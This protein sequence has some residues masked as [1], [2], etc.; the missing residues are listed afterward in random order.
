VEGEWERAIRCYLVALDQDPTDLDVYHRLARLY[1][2][3][4]RDHENLDLLE[5]AGR[6]GRAGRRRATPG[7]GWYERFDTL[8]SEL[9]AHF[10]S[11]GGRFVEV[12]PDEPG[13]E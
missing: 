10:E 4:G 1:G 6:V 9:D 8:L 7:D 3:L 13:P 12:E 11:A 5:Q 2:R